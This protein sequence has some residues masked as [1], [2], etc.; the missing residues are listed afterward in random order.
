M[1]DDG[2]YG[3]DVSECCTMTAQTCT[4]SI[5][6]AVGQTRTTCRNE[7]SETRGKHQTKIEELKRTFDTN[8]SKTKAHM[9]SWNEHSLRIKKLTEKLIPAAEKALAE[10]YK[11]CTNS[12]FGCTSDLRSLCENQS[13]LRLFHHHGTRSTGV[14]S[15]GAQ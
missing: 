11:S 6:S 9:N 3:T 2:F 5:Y 4:D 10:S 7:Q 1:C 13:A 15:K 14:S 12:Q 8:N